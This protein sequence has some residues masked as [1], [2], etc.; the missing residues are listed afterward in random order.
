MP[1]INDQAALYGRLLY[2]WRICGEYGQLP[3]EY[4]LVD[5]IQAAELSRAIDGASATLF[6]RCT[7][8]SLL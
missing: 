7:P 5:D 2:T 6:H 4:V 8:D 3:R 1:V